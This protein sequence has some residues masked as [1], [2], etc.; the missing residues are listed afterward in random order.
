MRAEQPAGEAVNVAEWPGALTAAKE[1]GLKDWQLTVVEE[2]KNGR[3][4]LLDIGISDN[5]HIKRQ[6]TVQRGRLG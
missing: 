5:S 3:N 2:V 4:C 6:L 1:V